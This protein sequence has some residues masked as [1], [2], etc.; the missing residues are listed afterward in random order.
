MRDL[1]PAIAERDV[2]GDQRVDDAIELPDTGAR[3][4][5][6]QRA[7]EAHEGDAIAEV[8]GRHGGIYAS[9]IRIDEAGPVPDYVHFHEI[10]FH[11]RREFSLA[12]QSTSRSSAHVSLRCQVSS[13]LSG[14]GR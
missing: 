3:G 8:V 1:R 14:S 12:H 4:E 10:H 9:H 2:A 7:A 13:H 5:P 11:F 6:V